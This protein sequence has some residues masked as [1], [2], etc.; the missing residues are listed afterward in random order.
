MKNYVQSG[1]VLDYTNSTEAAILSGDVVIVGSI[2]GIAVGDIAIDET[3]CVDTEGVFKL[4][5]DAPLEI[6][7]GDELFWNT[8]DKEVT[9]TGT[10]TPLGIAFEA[11]ASADTTV[12]VKIYGQGNGIPV[13]AAVAALTGTLTGTVNGAMV[14]VAATAAATAGGATP[15][16]TD[17]D[18]GIATAVASIVTGVNEQNKEFLTTLNAVIA[19]LKAAGL[20]TT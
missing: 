2:A 9:K 11:A 3:G 18:A 14:N 20:M 1:K 5:K 12:N 15:S 17:V 13:A 19:S 8:T 6:A 4:T 10:D 7:Q 16:A